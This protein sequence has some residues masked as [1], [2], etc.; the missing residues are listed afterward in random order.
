M[1]IV[2]PDVGAEIAFRLHLFPQDESSATIY[3][4][5]AVDVLLRADSVVYRVSRW[6]NFTIS[7]SG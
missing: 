4:N 3:L 5:V 6:Y 2:W 1:R 7:N